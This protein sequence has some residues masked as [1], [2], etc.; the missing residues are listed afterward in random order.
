MSDDQAEQWTTVPLCGARTKSGGTCRRPAGEGTDHAA[1]DGFPGVGKCRWHLGRTASH[2][3]AAILE[4]ARM[5]AVVMGAPVDITP[6]EALSW[7]IRIAAG[8]VSYCSER[9][10]ELAP[11][12]ALVKDE[13]YVER[14][15]VDRGEV[16][17]LVERRESST[18]RLHMWVE[19]RAAAMERLAKFS[20]VAIDAGLQE[21]EVA[22]AE[23]M[24]AQIAELL[25]A[26]LGDL[27]VPLNDPRT[28]EV[29]TRHM[30]ALERARNGVAS[31]VPA[32]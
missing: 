14:Q 5:R 23:R 17:D 31:L 27:G 8:E 29:V 1:K 9:I 6:H 22:L 26:V 4:Q 15:H 12:E 19:A 25:R 11:D 3:K 13:S 32:P 16:Y 7:C 21:R 20:K 10:A 28:R 2:Q 30:R 24:G 18:S